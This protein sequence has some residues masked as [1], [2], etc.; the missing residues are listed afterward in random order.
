MIYFYSYIQIIMLS[1]EELLKDE[2]NKEAIAKE[3]R[4]AKRKQAR[5]ARIER[6]NGPKHD[7]RE[8]INDLATIL[9]D[10]S[11]IEMENESLAAFINERYTTLSERY[12]DGDIS[13]EMYVEF[14]RFDTSEQIKKYRENVKMIKELNEQYA[15]RAREAS[16]INYLE[17]KV[18]FLIPGSG[19]FAAMRK[20]YRNPKTEEAMFNYL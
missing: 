11:I 5:I 2:A 12:E 4:R 6:I 8:S 20:A 15:I 14:L 13:F 17:K 9:E 16:R 18:R 3:Q 1:F 19:S 10:K 7:F